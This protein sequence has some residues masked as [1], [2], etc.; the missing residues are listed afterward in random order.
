MLLADAA[1]LSARYPIWLCDIWGV[2]HDGV[3]CYRHAPAAL[4]AHRAAGGA[5]VLISNAPRPAHSVIEQLDK[6]GCPRG[7]YDAVV[8]SGD[9]TLEMAAA[10]AGQSY[11]LVGPPDKDRHLIER[12]GNRRVDEVECVIGD[13]AGVARGKAMWRIMPGGLPHGRR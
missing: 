2:I 13:I 4:A 12:I 1:A 5:V 3:R 7:A 8:T 10:R 11:L 6:L 9:I